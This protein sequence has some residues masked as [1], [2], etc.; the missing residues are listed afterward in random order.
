MQHATEPAAIA[1]MHSMAHSALHC[2]MCACN[3]DME[4]V[5]SWRRIMVRATAT[6]RMHIM[7]YTDTLIRPRPSTLPFSRRLRL[8]C[9]LAPKQTPVHHLQR[10]QHL[11][12][13]LWR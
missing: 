10:P 12:E 2:I 4:A 11:P 6:K 8:L 9:M 5:K 13:K 7:A 3:F 1:H